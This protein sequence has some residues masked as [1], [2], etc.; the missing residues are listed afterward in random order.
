[1]NNT[2]T[3]QRFIDLMNTENY[4]PSTI[5]SYKYHVKELFKFYPMDASRISN[6]MVQDYQVYIIN[7]RKVSRSWQNQS[8]NAIKLFYRKV[9]GKWIKEYA[10]TR[11]RKSFHLPTVLS[12]QE[13]QSIIETLHNLKHKAIISLIYS[14]GLRISECINMRIRD[15]DS[16]R[17]LVKVVGGKGRKDR[18]I[19]L[20]KQVL[21]LLRDYYSKHKPFQ[22]LF[23]NNVTPGKQYSDKSI[24]NIFNRTVKAVGITKRATV[25]TLRHSFATHHV[26]KGTNLAIIQKLLGH[27]NIKTTMIYVHVAASLIAET[28]SP[29]SMLNIYSDP[30]EQ[31]LKVA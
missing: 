10:V 15:I 13:V 12:L 24:Q 8:I 26:E 4:S 2:K 3:I 30:S 6:D 29:A 17:M 22:Y 14:C 27:K 28:E 5:E 21:L 20:D 11:P 18:Y 9:Y 19:P 23:E 25:H 31:S 7:V 16:D 1:M